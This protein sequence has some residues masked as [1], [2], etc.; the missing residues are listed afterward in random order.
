MSGETVGDFYAA[1]VADQLEAEQDR[2]K[3]LDSRA[4]GV[5][6]S[7]GTFATLVFAFAAFVSTAEERTVSPAAA[8]ALILSLLLFTAS[9]VLA[10]LG[11]RLFSYRVAEVE[12]LRELTNWDSWRGSG[13]EGAEASWQIARANLT[14]VATLRTG[15]NTKSE[16][17]VLALSSQVGAVA[18]LAAAVV[19]TII[20]SVP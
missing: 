12:D 6:T 5:I 18:S 13:T 3:T 2:R 11:S 8:A 14:T 17:V 15:N 19:L 7:S 9:S 10:L 16:W 20:A 1:F 4:V